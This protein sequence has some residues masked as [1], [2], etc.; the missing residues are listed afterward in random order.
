MIRSQAAL[1]VITKE[2]TIDEAKKI[3]RNGTVW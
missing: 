2:T 3:G 1:P